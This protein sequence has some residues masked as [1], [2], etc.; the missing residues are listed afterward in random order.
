V[1]NLAI[2]LAAQEKT[3]ADAVAVA[4]W[5]QQLSSAVF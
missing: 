4:H 2:Q 5:A 1:G 3:G